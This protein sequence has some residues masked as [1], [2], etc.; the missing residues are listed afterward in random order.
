M[1]N[2]SN[3]RQDVQSRWKYWDG[4]FLVRGFVHGYVGPEKCHVLDQ[5]RASL[6][7]VLF[8]I[9][10]SLRRTDTAMASLR[11]DVASDDED[12]LSNEDPELEFSDSSD[13]ESD[14]QREG[15]TRSS[16]RSTQSK[17]GSFHSAGKQLGPARLD[18]VPARLML[19]R[20]FILGR[21]KLCHFWRV[22]ASTA[23]TKADSSKGGLCKARMDPVSAS[24]VTSS[25]S[26]SH[27][28]WLG[29]L[30][31]PGYSHAGG[32]PPPSKSPLS[33]A[34]VPDSLEDGE[35]PGPQAPTFGD[36]GL[37]PTTALP[38]RHPDLYHPGFCMLRPFLFC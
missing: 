16:G 28:L 13:G 10:H 7:S 38:L 5:A 11:R 32:S 29:L 4:H 22:N 14:E 1:L 33:S 26:R 2:Q 37:K 23:A 15:P 30:N 9:R 8:G 25:S 27:F 35:I 3:F 19:F 31:L 36:P 12:L 21:R 34:S 17:E 18:L 6:I 24:L 20:Q